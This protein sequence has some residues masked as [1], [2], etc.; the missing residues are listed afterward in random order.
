MTVV[1]GEH[2]SISALEA[3]LAARGVES[4]R[5]PTSHAFHSPMIEPIVAAFAEFVSTVRRTA[6]RQL[7]IS[8][9]TGEP[10][11]ET[12]AT[13][14]RY[15][16]QQMRRPVR[17]MDGVGKLMDP[18]LA[19]LE[20]GPGQALASLARQHP[21]RTPAQLVI[22]SL[23]A[24]QDT[25]GDLEAL[26]AAVGRLWS[27]G[28]AIDWS[29]FNA[30]AG[31]RRISL[32]AY[33]F[34]R[35]RYWVDPQRG[36]VPAPRAAEPASTLENAMPDTV[37]CMTP[38]TPPANGNVIA[39]LQT[40]FSELSGIDAAA[41][42][43]DTPFLELGL[44][45]LFLTQASNALHK[46]HG[47]RVSL[48]ELLDECATLSTLGARLAPT[49]AAAAAPA[50]VVSAVATSRPAVTGD[51]SRPATAPPENATLQQVFAQQLELMSRQLDMLRQAGLP[52]AAL[53]PSA[54]A[55]LA[56]SHASPA[57]TTPRNADIAPRAPVAFGPYRPPAKGP[58]A[59]LTPGQEESLRS[60][61]DRYVA[62]TRASKQFTAENRAHLADPRTVAGFRSIWK[63]MVYPIVVDRSSG[64]RLWDLDGNEYIDLTNG[65][66]TILFGHNAPFVREAIAAQLEQGIETGPQTPLA[67]EVA[68]LVCEMTGMARA[69]FCSTGSEAV[70]AAIRVARTVTGRDRIA[71]FAGAYHGIFDEVLVR[72]TLVNGTR[73]S[74][75]IAP[76]I[77]PN[78]VD[79]VVVLDYGTP[80]SLHAIRAM[81]HELA[82]VLVEP[83][84]SRRPDLQPREFL[85]GLR[86]ITAESE[87]A[88]VFDEVVT[89]FRAHPGGAQ[90]IFGVRA[91]IATYGKV[92]GGGL[93]IGIVAGDAKYLDAL[94]GGAWQYGDP[95][96]PEVGVTFF[97][98]TFVRHP[99]TLAVA[100]AALRKLRDEGPELQRALN[101]RT[102]GLVDAMNTHAQ[103]VQAPV[104]VTHFS[105]WFCFNFPPELP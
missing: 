45:S 79:N 40:L 18:A 65:F 54:P 60:F 10:V 17:F 27:A 85:Q 21:S 69:A 28:L 67:G 100:R 75:P 86:A 93:P 35:T 90:A 15:W 46:Q 42:E 104:R 101:L 29:A 96:S 43:P 20:V 23:H 71:L 83:V 22:A 33:P 8:S 37:G 4:R 41:L 38:G 51:T 26:F 48:R 94:D 78:M 12:E 16:A 53:S 84:Q 76:G 82:A 59:Q 3:R 97:A 50:T 98:G 49:L 25:A 32:P 68:K 55:P 92:I 11:T 72:G 80:E 74:V 88:L 56:P 70:T 13:D 36:G 57:T 52:G 105:S 102:S 103:A 89:G 87:T 91:D 34:E 81:R 2:E 73:R 19:L 24:G 39:A 44:D 31:S 77:A 64:S 14:P 62:R 7:W 58:A 5:L 47:V 61:I 1:A 95:S 66:G 63:E 6:P 99:L 9:M 30:G